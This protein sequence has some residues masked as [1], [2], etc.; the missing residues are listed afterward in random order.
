MVERI[1]GICSTSH[2]IASVQAIEDAGDIE[3]PERALYIRTVI[4]ELERIEKRL[5]AERDEGEI[6]G[7][8]YGWGATQGDFK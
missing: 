3:V 1:C 6:G 7:A 2:P 5:I 8:V 4:A